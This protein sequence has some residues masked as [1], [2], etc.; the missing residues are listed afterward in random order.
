M[1][2]WPNNW[3]ALNLGGGNC[4]LLPSSLRYQSDSPLT[5]F[6]VS[7]FLATVEPFGQ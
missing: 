6:Q 3:S 7:M 4:R 1:K 5:R 2:G